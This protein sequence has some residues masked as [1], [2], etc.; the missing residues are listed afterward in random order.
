MIDDCADS[1]FGI[2]V[3]ELP[4]GL[5]MGLR[6]SM[7][8]GRYRR[9]GCSGLGYWSVAMEKVYGGIKRLPRVCF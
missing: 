5:R 3:D 6:C 7:V 2:E 4:D 9:P 1:L 8:G